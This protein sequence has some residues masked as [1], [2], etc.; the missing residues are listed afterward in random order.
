[1][2][3]QRR[4]SSA[5]TASSYEIRRP[6]QSVPFFSDSEVKMG[7]GRHSPTDWMVQVSSESPYSATC[8]PDKLHVAQGNFP[9]STRRRSTSSF[10][11][12]SWWIKVFTVVSLVVTLYTGKQMNE[13]SLIVRKMER[14]M[15]ELRQSLEKNEIELSESTNS[16]S[17]VK[18]ARSEVQDLNERLQ[19]EA[20]MIAEMEEEGIDLHAPTGDKPLDT[21]LSERLVSLRQHWESLKNFV[22]DQSRQAVV[23]RFGSGPHQVE[24]T[25]EISSKG[26]GLVSPQSFTVEL[27]SINE[28]PHSVFFFLDTSRNWCMLT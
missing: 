16:L 19:H 9:S 15:L 23:E 7:D 17:K 8:S 22:Q 13:S 20:K 26:D 27:A 5:S 14:E 6:D 2:V 11:P 18:Q 10:E 24:M 12:Y 4:R 21:W 28:M 3:V 25:V 1:M